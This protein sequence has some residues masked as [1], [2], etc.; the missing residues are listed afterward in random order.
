VRAFV[1]VSLRKA[2][3]SSKIQLVPSAPS[4]GIFVKVYF[5]AVRGF[6]KAETILAKNFHDLTVARCRVNF[7]TIF[8]VTVN[9]IPQLSFDR[10]KGIP[11]C[12]IGVLVGMVQLRFPINHYFSIG[13]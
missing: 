13:H 7:G 5:R 12:H 1:A 3:V 6:D 9:P 10:V 8:G 2:Y 11:Y 4:D